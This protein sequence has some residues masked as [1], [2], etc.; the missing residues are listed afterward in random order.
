MR[1]QRKKRKE[2]RQC[3]SPSKE[4][5]VDVG[6][7]VNSTIVRF[8][9]RGTPLVTNPLVANCVNSASAQH[10]NNAR[11]IARL[12]ITISCRNSNLRHGGIFLKK[13]NDEILASGP[14]CQTTSQFG[15]R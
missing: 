12:Q 15:E 3:D 9:S 14:G 5:R 1:A 4:A 7:Y 13:Q 2:I 10:T 6:N 11:K 8:F